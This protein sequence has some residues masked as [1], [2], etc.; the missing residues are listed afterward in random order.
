MFVAKRQSPASAERATCCLPLRSAFKIPTHFLHQ[1]PYTCGPQYHFDSE[2]VADLRPVGLSW[3]LCCPHHK[4]ISQ[5][6]PPYGIGRQTS[7]KFCPLFPGLQPL[8]VHNRLPP[9]ILGKHTVT[10]KCLFRLTCRLRKPLLRTR[11]TKPQPALWLFSHLRRP[12][13]SIVT[14]SGCRR[15]TCLQ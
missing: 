5:S 13:K 4:S 10:L 2:A 14:I 8:V 6:L 15:L 3:Q 7:E 9:H 11:S 12:T 1:L